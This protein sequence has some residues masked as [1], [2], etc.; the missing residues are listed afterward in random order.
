M[1][2]QLLVVDDDP[3]LLRPGTRPATRSRQTR[4]R[5]SFAGWNTTV[6]WA[7]T[8]VAHRYLCLERLGSSQHGA[9]H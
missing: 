7:P 6:P 5:I 9:N 3:S 1:A 4:S 2:K 8:I